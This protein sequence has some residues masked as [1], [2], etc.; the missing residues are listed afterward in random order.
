MILSHNHGD[1]TGGLTTLRREL[2]KQNPKALSRAHVGEGIFSLRTTPD[3][4]EFNGL[5]PF[6]A[7]YE[8]LG[9]RF[10]VHAKPEELAP[11]VWFTGPVPRKHPE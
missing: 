1:H 7:E 4:R 5:T 11:G 3:G 10:I 6:K 2:Q 8:A 9:G